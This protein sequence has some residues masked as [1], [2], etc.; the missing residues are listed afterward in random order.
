MVGLGIAVGVS[1]VLVGADCSVVGAVVGSAV[2][3][4]GAGTAVFDGFDGFDGESD[5]REVGAGS[6]CTGAG[7]VGSGVGASVGGIGDGREVAVA[8]GATATTTTGCRVGVLTG[9]AVF[10]GV[11]GGGSVGSTAAGTGICSG[12]SG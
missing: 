8:V 12:A 10:V 1:G 11:L 3:G 9:N 7:R 5:G 6:G 2:V 4:D